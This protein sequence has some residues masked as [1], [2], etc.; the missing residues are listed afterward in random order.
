M[1]PYATQFVVSTWSIFSTFALPVWRVMSSTAYL[2]LYLY[3]LEFV[4]QLEITGAPLWH[5]CCPMPGYKSSIFLICAVNGHVMGCLYSRL[6]V[7]INTHMLNSK[8]LSGEGSLLHISYHKVLTGLFFNLSKLDNYDLYNQFGVSKSFTFYRVWFKA[9]QV[10]KIM[11]EDA[12]ILLHRLTG[13]HFRSLFW[14][15]RM[16]ILRHLSWTWDTS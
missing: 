9:I 13:Q 6:Y 3:C 2:I 16:I 8:W 10:F 11:E 14:S 1:Y 15:A 4:K 12:I 5:V 7:L